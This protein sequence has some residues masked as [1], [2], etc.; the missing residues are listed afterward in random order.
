[1][2]WCKCNAILLKSN[3]WYRIKGRE[4]L[5]TIVIIL[6]HTVRPYVQCTS[7]TV[8]YSTVMGEDCPTDYGTLTFLTRD[9]ARPCTEEGH[10][11]SRAENMKTA[12]MSAQHRSARESSPGL[13][14][15]EVHRFDCGDLYL[16]KSK[17][18]FIDDQCIWKT[19]K[20]T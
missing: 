8:E 18:P 15:A 10:S 17:L 14:R 4:G 13:C 2:Q 9:C 5:T 16:H 3:K 19:A 1:M 6:F 12:R 20:R 7:S 11:T